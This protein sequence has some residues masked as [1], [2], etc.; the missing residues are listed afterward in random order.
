MSATLIPVPKKE[1][2]SRPIFKHLQNAKVTEIGHD[3]NRGIQV[4]VIYVEFVGLEYS[5]ADSF[6]VA[7]DDAEEFIYQKYANVFWEERYSGKSDRDIA[8]DEFYEDVIESYSFN[9][10]EAYCYLQET[11]EK[12]IKNE[13]K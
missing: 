2:V 8:V 5:I 3:L 1:A 10:A 11:Y 13:Q 4:Y 12:E 7:V 6:E 9:Q